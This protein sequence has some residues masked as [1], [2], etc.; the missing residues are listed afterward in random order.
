MQYSETKEKRGGGFK[1]GEQ[2]EEEREENRRKERKG[3]KNLKDKISVKKTVEFEYLLKLQ[4]L[5]S[6]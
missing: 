5:R 2:W 3:E 1:K 4:Y 6:N